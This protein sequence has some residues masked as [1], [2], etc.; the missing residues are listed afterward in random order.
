VK[1]PEHSIASKP[2]PENVQG[3]AA[4]TTV[5]IDRRAFCRSSALA[6]GSLAILKPL[7]AAVPKNDGKSAQTP[8]AKP[9]MSRMVVDSTMARYPNAPDFGG[10]SYFCSLYMIGQY[11]VY[12]RTQDAAYLKYIQAWMNAYVD[13][14]GNI[15]HELTGLDYMQP[16]NLMLLLYA[17]TKE[18]R[19]RLA[20]EKIHQRFATYPRTADGGFWHSSTEP[21]K[22]HDLWL[23][24][25]Y[26]ALPFLLRYAKLFGGEQAAY[27]EA[28]KQLLLDHEHN[29]SK[30]NGLLYHAYDERG[31][32]AWAQPVNHHSSVFWCRAIGWYGMALVD[33]LDVLPKDHPQ[34]Q[35]LIAIVS[36][37]VESLAEYQDAQTGL[38]FQ[39]VDQAKLPGNWLETSSSSM[40]TYTI[41]IAVKRGYVDP[42]FHAAAARGY[43]GV[44][45][46]VSVKPDGLVDIYNIC[47]GTDVGEAAYY[48]ARQ[49]NTN[50]PH[51]LGAFL[52]MNEE[53]NTSLGSM[54]YPR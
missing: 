41:D 29:G 24:G 6:L 44:L 3:A 7:Y 5:A 14:K 40:F 22:V 9:D 49:R 32:A 19:Y 21:N 37:L 50:D 48:L 53:W 35:A 25:T 18:E 4:N 28:L 38:W 43:A 33:T 2:Q 46:Q 1:R 34:R 42:K 11:M 31:S 10:Y 39:I 17:E 26:M 12:E 54:A 27:N 51:G 30:M 8:A 15:D 16:G 23:D 52:L 13:A 20:A 45:T 36:S 47:E